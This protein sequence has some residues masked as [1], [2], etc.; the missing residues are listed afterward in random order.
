MNVPSYVNDS[1]IYSSVKCEWVR[2]RLVYLGHITQ[3]PTFS[4]C[5]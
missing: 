2:S 4:W 3:L 5:R 1:L